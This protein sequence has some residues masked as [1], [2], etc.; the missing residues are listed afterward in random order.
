MRN[1][2]LFDA[3]DRSIEALVLQGKEYRTDCLARGEEEFRP[4]LFP[5]LAVPLKEIWI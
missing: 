4:S 1:Y 5:G 3:F 2:W